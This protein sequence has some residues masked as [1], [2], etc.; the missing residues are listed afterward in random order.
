MFGYGKRVVRTIKQPEPFPYI[1]YADTVMGIAGT[2]MPAVTAPEE[3]TVI[4]LYHAH[5]D[6]RILTVAHPMLERIFQK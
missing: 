1:I 5:I 2:G 4:G 6:K 3:D